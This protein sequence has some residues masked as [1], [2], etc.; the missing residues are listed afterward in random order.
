MNVIELAMLRSRTVI[1]SLLV[2]LIGG[3]V[4]YSTIPKEAVL[5][6]GDYVGPGYSLPTPAMI[7]AVK[8]LAESEEFF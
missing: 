5:C 4:A 3:V 2:V 1:L 7:E 6:F 8:L